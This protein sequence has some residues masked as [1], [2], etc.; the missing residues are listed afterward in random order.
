MTI[1]T[2]SLTT[3]RGLLLG[4][5]NLAAAGENLVHV[6]VGPGDDVHGDELA[7]AARSGRTGIGG[8]L[9]CTDVAADHDRCEVAWIGPRP[10]YDKVAGVVEDRHFILM[11]R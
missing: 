2:A 5:W 10:F 7:H 9:D 3:A 8:S 11:A 1:P 4:G 6:L